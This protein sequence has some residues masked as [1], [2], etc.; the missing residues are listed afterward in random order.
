MEINQTNATNTVFFCPFRFVFGHFQKTKYYSYSYLVILGGLNIIHM[1]SSAQDGENEQYLS[2][3]SFFLSFT[4]AKRFDFLKFH[5]LLL[6]IDYK[7]ML[8]LMFFAFA[9]QSRSRN[10]GFFRLFRIFQSVF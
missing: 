2:F 6:T 1:G 10:F 5:Q 9:L 7:L 4:V 8:T 3:F